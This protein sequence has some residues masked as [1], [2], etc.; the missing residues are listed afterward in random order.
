MRSPLPQDTPEELSS[1]SYAQLNRLILGMGALSKIRKKL[2]DARQR[3]LASSAIP[4][5]STL[6]EDV[7]DLPVAQDRGEGAGSS[8]G[9]PFVTDPRFEER[10]VP[11]A[12]PRGL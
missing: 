3:D 7:A 11:K 1:Y 10:T 5:H 2:N 6:T 9:P 12:K 8:G 4:E